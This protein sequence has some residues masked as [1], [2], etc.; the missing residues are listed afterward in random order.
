[1]VPPRLRAWFVIH[2]I[3]DLVFAIP[4][5]LAPDTMLRILGWPCVDPI[6]ARLV[7]AALFGIGIQSLLARGEGVEAYRAMLGLKVIWSASAT[8][9]I[10]ISMLQGGPPLGWAFFAIFLGFNGVWTYYRWRLRDV[11]APT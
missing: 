4:L 3:A 8:L 6:S 9:G 7:A 11:P 5:F 2:F 1:M 10:L